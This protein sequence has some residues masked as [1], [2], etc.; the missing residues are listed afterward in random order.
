[1]NK[2][3]IIDMLE[4]TDIKLVTGIDINLDWNGKDKCI[5]TYFDSTGKLEQMTRC[6]DR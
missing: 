4:D 5:I 3:L 2:E 6:F 1:M